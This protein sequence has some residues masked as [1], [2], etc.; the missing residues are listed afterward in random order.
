MSPLA[1]GG[2]W[3]FAS[4]RGIDA[5]VFNP[6]AYTPANTLPLR[7]GGR[8]RVRTFSWTLIAMICYDFILFD[9][10]H[11][12]RMVSFDTDLPEG[13]SF[14]F[15]TFSWTLIALIYSDFILFD[16]AHLLRISSLD[17]D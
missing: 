8:L 1:K 10:A 6:P 2:A 13:W 3:D 14:C 12:S 11:L 17:A 4:G 15:R 7:Q 9:A 16:A 5:Y